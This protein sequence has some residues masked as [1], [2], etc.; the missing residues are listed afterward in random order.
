M[1]SGEKRD[2]FV[3]KL[4]LLGDEWSPLRALSACGQILHKNPGK[5]QTPPHSGNACILGA[6]GPAI[7]VGHA[8]ASADA[9]RMRIN[10]HRC[11][12]SAYCAKN[13]I[14]FFTYKLP[15]WLRFS[16]SLGPEPHQLTNISYVESGEVLSF[17]VNEAREYLNIYISKIVIFLLTLEIW[18]HQLHLIFYDQSQCWSMSCEFKNALGTGS[19]AC[20]LCCICCPGKAPPQSASSCDDTGHQSVCKHSCTGYTWMTFLQYT[21][22]SHALSNH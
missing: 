14:P 6:S 1:V 5:G 2:I 3:G 13:D 19:F 12:S 20:K 11:A 7:R 9:H 17:C 16:K 15:F 18:Y 22:S 4:S 10:A 21:T 8:D